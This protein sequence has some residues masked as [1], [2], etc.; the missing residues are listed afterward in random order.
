MESRNKAKQQR[1]ILRVRKK[2][3]SPDDM[4]LVPRSYLT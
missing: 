4:V 2:E 1:K 3:K